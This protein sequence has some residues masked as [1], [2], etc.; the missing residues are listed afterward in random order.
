[1]FKHYLANLFCLVIVLTALTLMIGGFIGLL[2]SVVL[3]ISGM[4]ATVG[5]VLFIPALLVMTVG[6]SLLTWK[7]TY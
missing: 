7:F 2:F 3:V 1:M 6:L 4:S 5:V